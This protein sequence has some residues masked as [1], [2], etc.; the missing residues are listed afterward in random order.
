MV[1]AKAGAK[2]TAF[3]GTVEGVIG[4][5]EK[6]DEG[7][8]YDPLFIPV[9]HCETFA[10]ISPELKNNMSHRARALE[11]VTTWLVTNHPRE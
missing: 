6:G 3:H 1:I 4:T 9:G 8:G 11:K 10:Q 5:V 2:I 7:F